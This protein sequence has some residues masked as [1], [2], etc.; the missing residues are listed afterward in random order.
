MD[1]VLQEI[2]DLQIENEKA[3]K[4]ASFLEDEDVIKIGALFHTARGLR[5]EEEKIRKCREILTKKTKIFSNFRGILRFAVQARLA[6]AP[7]PE[8]YMDQVLAVYGKLTEGRKLPGEILVMAA[9]TICDYAEG[10]DVDAIIAA[11]R[12]AHAK[13]KKQHKFLTD[14]ND[15]P[16]IAMMVQSGKNVDRTVEEVEAIYRALKE[17]IRISSDT[18]QSVALILALSDKP[19][20]VKVDGFVRL[21]QDL[22]EE[23]YATSKSKV[24]SVYAAF[25]DLTI[26]RED[27]VRE[28]GEVKEF[29]KHQRGYGILSNSDVRNVMAATLVLLRH[30]RDI[31]SGTSAMV[32][33]V[34][35]EEVIFTV[36]MTIAIAA[37]VSA[38][39][40]NTD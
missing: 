29:L 27:L 11:T 21:Y 14:D 37:A 30:E 17:T 26:P 6:A 24:M 7:D 5:A 23:G 31:S 4:R 28:I 16:Y 2:C 35:A 3:V 25:A 32:S 39:I 1:Q 8:G 34:I 12:E 9:M 22:K 40:S 19:A 33:S 36:L 15:M 20:E 38:A 10:Q 13:I 18:A